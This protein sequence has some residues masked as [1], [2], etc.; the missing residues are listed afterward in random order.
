MSEEGDGVVWGD[1]FEGAHIGFS[2]ANA[3]FIVRS[4]EKTISRIIAEA[5]GEIG[6]A[7]DKEGRWSNRFHNFSLTA[8]VF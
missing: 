3:D 2:D 7:R 8:C 4:A 1:A 5:G 6:P